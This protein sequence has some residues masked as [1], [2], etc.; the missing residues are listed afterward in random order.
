MMKK[1]TSL[2]TSV[3]TLMVL[4][5]TQAYAA[6]PWYCGWWPSG[7]GCQ[8]GGGGGG[9]GTSVPEPMVLGLMVVA[10]AVIGVALYRRKR[11][12]H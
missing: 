6:A 7:P 3:S 10:L 1:L 9:G 8:N 4:G 2:V 11:A 12:S 5:T